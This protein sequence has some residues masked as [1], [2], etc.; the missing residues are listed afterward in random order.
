MTDHIHKR[1]TEEQVRTILNRY[2]KKE[3]RAYLKTPDLLR[4]MYAQAN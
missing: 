3:L 2:L 4:T 1:L